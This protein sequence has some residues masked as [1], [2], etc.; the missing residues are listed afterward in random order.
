[1]WAFICIVLTTNLVGGKF[2]PRLESGVLC[3]HIVGFFGIMIPLVA[4]AHHRSK[5]E[6]FKEFL[7]GGKFHSQGLSW[8]VG[9]SGAAFAF[10][11]GDASVH[12]SSFMSSLEFAYGT[13]G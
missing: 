13:S 8:F 2:L 5:E 1:M 3:F 12:V 11:G 4:K 10:A 7:N 6:V 9:L